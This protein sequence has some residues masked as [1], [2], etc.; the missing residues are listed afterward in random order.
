M[1]QETPEEDFIFYNCIESKEYIINFDDTPCNILIGKTNDQV[2]FSGSHFY[3]SMN[4]NEF[5]L[6]IKKNFKSINE[7]YV[8]IIKIFDKKNVE[9][10]YDEKKDILLELLQ[11]NGQKI[12]LSMRYSQKNIGYIINYL[13]CKNIKLENDLNLI[14]EE[15]KNLK[16]DC[17]NIKQKF[18]SLQ[19]ENNEIKKYNQQ[20]MKEIDLIKKDNKQIKEENNKIKE[21]NNNILE[22]IKSIE[23]KIKSYNSNN[24]NMAFQNNF[25]NNNNNYN[26][27]FNNN[28]NFNN[29]FVPQ[30]NNNYINNNFNND[31]NQHKNNNTF[32]LIFKETGGNGKIITLDDCL[33]SDKISDLME[34]YRKKKG[35]DSNFYFT[36]NTVVLDQNS[37][38]RENKLKNFDKINVM[39]IRGS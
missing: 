15:N 36:H 18:K 1:K 23:N 22:E 4:L 21:K 31:I 32:S 16:N 7:L 33:P 39:R 8:Y 38:L 29:N 19:D 2:I 27:N 11:L 28:Y 34:K 13:W 20:L 10:K 24:N 30:N 37:T 26:N 17:I 25:I 14:Q 12:R 3:T 35:G 9:I 6:I 5:N